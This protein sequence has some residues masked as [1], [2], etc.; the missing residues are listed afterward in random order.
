LNITKLPLGF[1]KSNLVDSKNENNIKLKST[2][3]VLD[4]LSFEN[5]GTNQSFP[6]V[7]IQQV[8]HLLIK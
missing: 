2:C 6:K 3:E 5:S 8:Q 1:R 7:N 4:E